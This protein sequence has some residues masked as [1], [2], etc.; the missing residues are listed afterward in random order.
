MRSTDPAP[1]PWQPLGER[2]E[3]RA[4][5]PPTPGPVPVAPGVLRGPDGK[6]YTDLP[7]PKEAP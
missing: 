5:A 1:E 3:K 6:F 4:P 7:L 2:V